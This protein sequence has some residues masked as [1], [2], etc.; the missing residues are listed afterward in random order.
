MKKHIVVLI[1]LAFLIIGVSANGNMMTLDTVE[2]TARLKEQ[3]SK[4]SR[5]MTMTEVIHLI[6]NPTFDKGSGRYIPVYLFVGGETLT[7]DVG[8]DNQLIAARNK[9]GFDLLTTEYAAKVAN[10]SIIVEN[11]QMITSNPV[12]TINNR[13]YIPLREVCNFIGYNVNWDGESGVISLTGK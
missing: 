9:D 2:G 13:T 7:L 11:K 5:G 8:A 3:V 1:V 4:L 6:G 12:V 10:V